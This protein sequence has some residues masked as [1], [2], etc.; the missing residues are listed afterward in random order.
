MEAILFKDTFRVLRFTHF[1]LLF[2]KSSFYFYF[3]KKTNSN[4]VMKNL[5][6]YLLCALLHFSAMA[7]IPVDIGNDTTICMGECLVLDPG[8]IAD[9]YQWST[10]DTTQAITICTNVD[11]TILLSVFDLSGSTGIDSIHINT[12]LACDLVWPGDADANGIVNVYDILPIGQG[13]GFTGLVRPGATPN[14][15]GQASSDWAG[16]AVLNFKHADCNGNG[17]IEYADFA[18]VQQNY[19]LTHPKRQMEQ[20]QNNLPVLYIDVPEDTLYAGDTL[21]FNIGIDG[22]SS[23]NVELY[24]IAFDMFYDVTLVDTSILPTYDY[25][26]C[27]LGTLGQDIYTLEHNDIIASY[28]ALGIT[29]LDQINIVGQGGLVDVNFILIDDIAGKVDSNVIY[30]GNN[31]LWVTGK[32]ADGTNVPLDVRGDTVV[33]LQARRPNGIAGNELEA[34]IDIFPNPSNGALNISISGVIGSTEI[35]AYNIIGELI[36]TAVIQADGKLQMNTSNWPN[37]NYMLQFV[38]GDATKVK[39]VIV[40]H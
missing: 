23:Q 32:L 19:G 14:W 37:G 3:T 8:N 21:R 26:D 40:A 30:I 12:L 13:Y 10:G 24:G 34:D 2:L 39:R 36:G 6:I 16:T 33:L 35:R 17:V 5:S 25:A 29:R 1:E 31:I 20:Q 28:L 9:S 18:A 22:D 38:N 11:T 4:L 27:F 7:Q 15:V